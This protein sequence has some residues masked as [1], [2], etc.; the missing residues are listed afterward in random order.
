MGAAYSIAYLS[1]LIS[2][3]FQRI[4]GDKER[5]YLKLNEVL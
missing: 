3:E 1:Q 2:D 5:D 4:L